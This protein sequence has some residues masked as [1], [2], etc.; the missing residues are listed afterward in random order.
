[1]CGIIAHLAFD[2]G[3]ILSEDQIRTL[4]DWHAHRG[5]DG[6]G[7][8][9]DGPAALGARRLAIVDVEGGQQPISTLDGRFTI[10]FNGEIYNHKELR[11]QLGAKGYAFKT[12]S[13]TE[14]ILNAFADEGPAC[15]RRFNGMFAFAIWDK[16][17]ASLF[18]ARDR[19]GIKPLYYALG[20]GQALF[21]SELRA[22]T[23]SG[24][25]ELSWDL[26]AL[27]DY[28]AYWYLCQPRTMF[29]EVKQLPP[30]HYAWVKDGQMRTQ[31]WW[32][33]PLEAESDMSL[34]EASL[35]L[36]A[37]LRDSIRLRMAADVPVGIFLSG[38]IDSGLMTAL[39]AREGHRNIKAF[40]IRFD[41]PSYDEGP[42]A[43]L[44]A[45]FNQVELHA[46]LLK[47]LTPAQIEEVI[48]KL[49]GPI[50]NASY[51]PAYF[52]SKLASGYVKSVLS[53]DG[54][55]E[56]FGGYPTYQAVYY[57]D[58]WRHSPGMVKAM[59]RALA[60][61]IPVSHQRISF[62]YRIKQLMK[63]I[64]GD[65]CFG[66]YVWRQ[67]APL[68]RQRSLMRPQVFDALQG[69]DPFCVARNC[70]ERAGKLQT[71]NQLMY[72]DLNTYLLNDHL[73]KIDRMSMACGLEVRLPY[74]DYRIVELAMRLPARHKVDFRR[75]KI[76]LKQIARTYLPGKVLRCPKKGL[77]SPIAGWLTGPLSAYA[78]DHLSGGIATEFFDPRQIETLWQEHQ[79]FKCDHSRL[80]WALLT[81]NVWAESLPAR[82]GIR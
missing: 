3:C 21:S 36:E 39:A 76:I 69:H 46:T 1:M 13:D 28:L 71:Q 7:L 29:N 14:V 74:L 35:Q 81:L 66:H 56:L 44:T 82:T 45:D 5:P 27:S 6:A 47:T 50:G 70:F 11:Q 16:K 10:V 18:V 77:T 22:I 73:C 54:G 12:Y 80:L 72:V 4:N 51:V 63:G 26:K 59:V 62:D 67:I 15:L 79:Q 58:L 65:Y 68:E 75:T 20:P 52:L 23:H 53:G 55:D 78:M 9:L 40:S 19:L 57:Q 24:F 49:D 31:C 48:G 17:Q 37:L 41:D 38:G 33:M 61:R 60:R 25:F 43:R 2:P 64:D 30:G 32:Q 8:F 42:L 34:K